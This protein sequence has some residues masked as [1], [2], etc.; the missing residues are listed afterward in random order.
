MEISIKYAIIILRIIIEFYVT[1]SWSR[2]GFDDLTKISHLQ[3]SKCDF[4]FQSTSFLYLHIIYSQSTLQ[5]TEF[6]L[7]PRIFPL[8]KGKI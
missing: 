8:H 4:C 7:P 2:T 6:L 1:P 5:Q 3:F